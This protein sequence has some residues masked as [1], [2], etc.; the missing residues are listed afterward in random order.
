MRFYTQPHR[1][2]CGIDL[3][4]RSMP[5]CILDQAGQVVFDRNLP[6]RPEAFLR[7]VAPFRDDV[8]VGVE[9]LFAHPWLLQGQQLT[10]SA[11]MH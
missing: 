7:A 8:I 5:V 6:A 10:S 1:C 3:H 2:Y 4:A 11:K 9:G